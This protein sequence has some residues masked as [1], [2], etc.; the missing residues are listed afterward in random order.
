MILAF[1]LPLLADTSLNSPTVPLVW[2]AIW[3]VLEPVLLGILVRRLIPTLP[4]W[5]DRLETVIASLSI[6]MII[7]VVVAANQ[8]QLGAVSFKIVSALVSLNLS[9]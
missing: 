1:W 8:E 3:M 4:D 7:M 9:A 5:W 2:N 6:V